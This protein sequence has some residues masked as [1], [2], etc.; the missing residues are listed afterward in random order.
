M[1]AFLVM[2]TFYSSVGSSDGRYT[3]VLAGVQSV[4]DAAGHHLLF[5]SYDPDYDAIPA[6]V[7]EN[8]VD[9]LLIW[10]NPPPAT[11]LR[12]TRMLPTVIAERYVEDLPADMV[13]YDHEKSMR[14]MLQHLWDLGHRHIAILDQDHPSTPQRLR[15][16]GAQQFFQHHPM[17]ASITTLS[18]PRPISPTTNEQVADQFIEDLRKTEPRPT[19]VVLGDRGLGRIFIERSHAAG[20][21]VPGELSVATLQDHMLNTYCDPQVTTFIVPTR[22]IGCAAAE[23]LL[24]R[25]EDPQCPPRELRILGQRVDR[26]SVAPPRGV[27]E[28]STMKSR[29]S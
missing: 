26:Q 21:D 10:S 18:R 11:L 7:A 5:S 2:P 6:S 1:I 25:I 17:P 19:A 8:R 20:L 24:Q 22:A 16:T 27:V 12:L 15:Q 14:L 13:L 28:V 23:M 29:T 4:L 3:D 9:G